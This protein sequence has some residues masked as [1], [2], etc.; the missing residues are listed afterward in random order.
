MI[1]VKIAFSRPKSKWAVGSYLIRSVERSKFS[2]V[3]LRWRAESLERELVY[4]AGHGMV[5]FL[6]GDR[7][8]SA[9]VTVVEYEIELTDEQFREM[10]RKCIDLAGISYG[11]W[12]LVG[13]G[14]QRV[15]GFRNPFRDGSKTY[16]CSE[17]VGE[18][19]KIIYGSKINVDLEFAGPAKLERLV[20]DLPNSRS[21]KI[22][23]E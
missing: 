17:L 20:R 9:A 8:D 22:E 5:H 12:Q 16:V 10:V 18:V 1:P 23:V 4:Q 19:L 15:F 13:M 7:F 21:I 14:L 3:L 2:H 6:S 11:Y